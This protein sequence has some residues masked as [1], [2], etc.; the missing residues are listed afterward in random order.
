MKKKRIIIISIITGLIV[1]GAICILI[2]KQP[3]SDNKKK[4]TTKKDKTPEVVEKLKIVDLESKTRPYAVVV[5][6]TPVA[7]KVQE[8]VKKAYIVYEIPTEGSTSRL[9]A[10]FKDVKDLTIGTIRSVRHNFIDFAY[11]SDAILVGHGWSHYAQDELRGSKAIINNINGMVDNGFWRNNPEGL[12]SEHTSYT[13]IENIEK[14]AKDKGYSLESSNWKLLNYSV[15]E[16]DLSNKE[17]V[18]NATKV[19]LPYGNITT[20][21]NYNAENKNYVKNVNGIDIV[22]H[23]TKENLTAKNIIIEKITYQPAS[24]NYYWNLNTVGSGD[25]Y[26]ITNGKAV[27]IKWNKQSRQDKTK[28]TYLDGKEIELNDG[29]TYIEVHVT[30][31]NETVE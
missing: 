28:Y 20:V 10:L 2:F 5:N 15:K 7:V 26:Y 12:A 6:N 17:G 14:T 27:K 9:I 21:F 25:G 19:T 3:K 16:I 1:I 29:N 22:D 30:S 4:T 13:S 23:A 24:D 8:G 18:M 31:K 11:E